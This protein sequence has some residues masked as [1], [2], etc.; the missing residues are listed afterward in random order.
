MGKVNFHVLRV[1]GFG[2]ISETLTFRLDVGGINVIYGKN[3]AGKTTV[4]SAFSW[5]VN[6]THLKPCKATDVP[7]FKHKRTG[8]W[9]GTRV[10]LTFDDDGRYYKIARHIKFKGTT[11]GV[12]GGDSLMLF[13][14]IEDN[15]ELTNDQH[16]GDIQDVIDKIIG[17]DSK[18]FLNSVVFGQGLTRLV[19]SDAKD[20]RDLFE[21]LFDMQFIPT[22]KAAADVLYNEETEVA[23]NLSREL[24]ETG[25]RIQG[26]D[27][28]IAREQELEEEREQD[29]LDNV[30]KL[31]SHIDRLT[32]SIS[33]LEA[34]T[35]TISKNSS[36]YKE[37]KKTW[38]G[39]VLKLD[40]KRKEF[41]EVMTKIA[42]KVKEFDKQNDKVSE[43]VE[44]ERAS[45][46]NVSNKNKEIL[47]CETFIDSH[48]TIVDKLVASRS[49]VL[50]E[51]PHCGAAIKPSKVKEARKHIEDSIET[52]NVAI[53][54]KK[55]L[56]QQLKGQLTDLEFV[57]SV[58][59]KNTHT[60]REVLDVIKKAGDALKT[61]RDEI[62]NSIQSTEDYVKTSKEH[63]DS[64]AKV[65]EK[66]AS[67]DKAIVE[68]KNSISIYRKQL[69]DLENSKEEP[70]SKI[71]ELE[72]RKSKVEKELYAISEKNT[73]AADKIKK[74][75]WWRTKALGSSGLKALIFNSMLVKLNTY[76]EK[77]ADMLGIRVKFSI[78]TTKE[79]RPFLTSCYMNGVESDYSTFSGGE[80]QRIDICMAF[81]M[82]DLVS[83]KLQS[84]VL[85]MDEVF[86]GLDEEGRN[87]VMFIIRNFAMQGKSVFVIS[88]AD[89]MD[90]S[91]CKIINIGGGGRTGSPTKIEI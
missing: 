65:T 77:Y 78:D 55:T 54:A 7:T 44:I 53:E 43:A 72:L 15:W 13:E 39:W 70:I 73:A 46:I 80:K 5:V 51:C 48:T 16:K 10:Q 33:V 87:I 18:A 85:I 75:Q 1:E 66:I 59:N 86:E 47:D 29:R 57:K 82:Y 91:Q 25:I 3:G 90:V 89:Y 14:R 12:V 56:L 79:S 45:N 6:K 40:I 76:V 81:A 24:A 58:N 42:D 36:G 20:K 35:A 38:E 83:Y 26:I 41:D 69:S 31:N 17:V 34:D 30:D 21:D 64:Y 27:D 60:L 9:R 71:P 74:I 23:N 2:S 50:T 19:S 84:N 37:A 52:E 22:L 88:H 8:K 63:L 11:E 62:K 4:V 68:H 67:N 28:A 32:K 49:E 61:S